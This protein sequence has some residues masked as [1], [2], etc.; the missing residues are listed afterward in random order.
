MAQSAS[1]SAAASEKRQSSETWG[2]TTPT[3]HFS[4]SQLVLQANIVA[5]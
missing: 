4:A 5:A 1:I 3:C 2:S